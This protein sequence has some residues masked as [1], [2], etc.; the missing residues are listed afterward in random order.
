MSRLLKNQRG[1]DVIEYDAV[2]DPEYEF[3][4]D[5]SGVNELLAGRSAHLIVTMNTSPLAY[6]LLRGAPGHAMM[7]RSVLDVCGV[8]PVRI[9]EFGSLRDAGES[10]RKQWLN[11]TRKMGR[12]L[13]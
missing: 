13:K 8:E 4:E 7:K 11:E 12:E 9:S 6:K 1:F 3:K 10:L 5:G 2:K